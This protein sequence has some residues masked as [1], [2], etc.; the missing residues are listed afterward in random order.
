MIVFNLSCN[1]E[2]RFEGWFV[3][4]ADY[5][6]QQQAALLNC[7]VCGSKDVNK[8]LHAPYVNT[9]TSGAGNGA[10]PQGRK[11]AGAVRQYG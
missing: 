7:P 3:S 11:T 1:N 2:H 5:D 9:G 6:R 8:G 4:A 10:A